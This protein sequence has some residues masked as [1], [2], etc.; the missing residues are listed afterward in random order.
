M[1]SGSTANFLTEL[2]SKRIHSDQKDWLYALHNSAIA[3]LQIDFSTGASG[4]VTAAAADITRFPIG[5]NIPGGI[6]SGTTS[7]T[8]TPKGSGGNTVGAVFTIIIDDRCSKY[9]HV[10]VFFL[11][12]YGAV[13]SFRFDRVRR[14]NFTSAKNT[15][16]KNPYALNN[17]AGTYAYNRLD[18]AKSDYYNEMTQ[19]TTLNSNFITEKEAQWLKQLINSPRVWMFDTQLI[20]INV[21]T[22]AYEQKYHI[23][24]KVFNLTLEV[25]HSFI[26]KAQ[27]L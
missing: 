25:E 12:K 26:D 24:D 27:A 15:F 20:P 5:A 8:I 1:A 17:S 10:D 13:E 18:H 9:D 2:T 6:P 4:T 19:V 7:Y 14:D 21:R 16:R 11:N 23:N 3:S 22:S